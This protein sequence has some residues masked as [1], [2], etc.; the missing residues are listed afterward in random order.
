MFGNRKQRHFEYWQLE[1]D[2]V[3]AQKSQADN[4]GF[5]L[6]ADGQRKKLRFQLFALRLTYKDNSTHTISIHT[7]FPNTT[8]IDFWPPLRQSLTKAKGAIRSQCPRSMTT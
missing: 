6:N 2:T 4:K 1:T 8:L 3:L 5:I 7:E